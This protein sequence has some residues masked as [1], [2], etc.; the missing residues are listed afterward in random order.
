[1]KDVQ[2]KT[3]SLIDCN[4]LLLHNNTNLKHPLSEGP[5]A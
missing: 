3:K 5:V 4:R 2:A 1:M